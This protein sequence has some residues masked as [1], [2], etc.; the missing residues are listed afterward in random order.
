M[1]PPGSA[2]DRIGSTWNFV[3][4]KRTS[5]PP[6]APH[7]GGF[8]P[9][10]QISHDPPQFDENG[11]YLARATEICDSPDPRPIAWDLLEISRSPIGSQNLFHG[12]SRRF[13]VCVCFCLFGCVGVGFV[14]GGCFV[15]LCCFWCRLR[16]WRRF[17]LFL[18]VRVGAWGGWVGGGAKKVG[19]GKSGGV[20][21]LPNNNLTVKTNIRI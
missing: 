7:G 8:A 14:R 13:F 10:T 4:S 15:C 18:F 16:S 19:G 1:S 3:I 6:K 20:I 21:N 2:V 11:H 17:R 9:S 12:L 5:R